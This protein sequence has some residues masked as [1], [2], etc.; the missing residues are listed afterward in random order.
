MNGGRT[1]EGNWLALILWY[2][3]GIYLQRL[4]HITLSSL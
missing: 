3:L 4:V 2:A 1:V